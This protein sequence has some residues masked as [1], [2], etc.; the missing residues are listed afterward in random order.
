MPPKGTRRP[1]PVK[2]T[3]AIESSDDSTEEENASPPSKRHKTTAKPKPAAKQRQSATAITSKPEDG[4]RKS[5][6][7][8]IALRRLIDTVA[9]MDT[10]SVRRARAMVRELTTATDGAHTKQSWAWL[11]QPNVGAQ[12]SPQTQVDL[13]L[14]ALARAGPTAALDTFLALGC[15]VARNG[16][17]V[18]RQRFLVKAWDTAQ[19][20]RDVELQERY[21][22][23]VKRVAASGPA[24]AAMGP[25][26]VEFRLAAA[27]APADVLEFVLR[28][29]DL[30]VNAFLLRHAS[31]LD[32][33]LDLVALGWRPTLTMLIEHGH[34][35]SMGG[36]VPWLT[37]VLWQT[38][39]RTVE[40]GRD[41]PYEK[42][43]SSVADAVV[44]LE[45]PEFW[46]QSNAHWLESYRALH[47]ECTCVA[48]ERPATNAAPAPLSPDELE[49]A[50]AIVHKA[51][52]L[53][54]LAWAGK[55]SHWP[56]FAAL[57]EPRY[58][59]AMLQLLL[60][61][62]ADV[63][64]C[65]CH[66]LRLQNIQEFRRPLRPRRNRARNEH[67]AAPH[68]HWCDSETRSTL[69]NPL[70]SMCLPW[71][72]AV[73]TMSSNVGPAARVS[74]PFGLNYIG[75][76]VAITHFLVF[77]YWRGVTATS[78]QI[79]GD[80][81][82]RWQRQ[83]SIKDLRAF[84]SLASELSPPPASATTA[85]TADGKTH[86]RRHLALA[87][88]RD[89]PI[90]RHLRDMHA[91]LAT[92]DAAPWTGTGCAA[93]LPKDL[94]ILNRIYRGIAHICCSS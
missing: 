86:G 11:S 36:V 54:R 19:A 92:R 62:P 89:A 6:S 56:A 21:G 66:M 31:T 16:G 64:S 5:P 50:L 43:P 65:R 77:L 4:K 46:Q 23:W 34:T 32:D 44:G 42:P 85:A 88:T 47:A 8:G 9:E 49:R 60:Q 71:L 29:I 37:P 94:V 74:P 63:P 38:L 39:Q 20:A 48:E 35:M 1:Q 83:P 28:S 70:Q 90:S 18:H 73:S 33:C 93:D 80:I 10:K 15:C 59:D 26:H 87:E 81:V 24:R 3:P 12:F 13:V 41:S 2:N 91:E 27:A 45:S 69:V 78:A 14:T 17:P 84:F 25:A 72:R 76:A 75:R 67:D 82:V 40:P 61:P 22:L 55:W 52:T 7:I 68:K 79:I 51:P 57:F 53:M 58:W 30:Q